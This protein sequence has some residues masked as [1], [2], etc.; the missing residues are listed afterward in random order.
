MDRLLLFVLA[1]L[2][3]SG[4]AEAQKFGNDQYLHKDRIRVIDGDTFDYR[5]TKIRVYGMQAPEMRGVCPA[6]IE[7][8]K[9]AKARA[10]D[11]IANSRSVWLR[12]VV[13]KNRTTGKIVRARD[14]YGRV[15]ARVFV[16]GGEWLAWMFP[17][18]LGRAWDGQGE[19]PSWCKLDG[20]AAA[21]G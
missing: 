1:M 17:G 8:G 6:E 14:R 11:M 12:F 4:V 16:D 10:V 7:L 19:K 5:G 20:G 18:G 15:L 21:S 2:M 3:F 13:Q 9:Q